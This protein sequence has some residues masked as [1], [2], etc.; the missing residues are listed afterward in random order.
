LYLI[1]I[2]KNYDFFEIKINKSSINQIFAEFLP[3]IFVKKKRTRIT[4]IFWIYFPF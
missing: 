4:E 1:L 3:G 2:Y